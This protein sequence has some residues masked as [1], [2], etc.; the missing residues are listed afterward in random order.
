M[1]NLAS[2]DNPLLQIDF[3]PICFDFFECTSTPYDRASGNT[4]L[5]VYKS[6]S[7]TLE[8]VLTE[9]KNQIKN[10]SCHQKRCWIKQVAEGNE[11]VTVQTLNATGSVD[12]DEDTDTAG[13]VEVNVESSEVARPLRTPQR[14][15]ITRDITDFDGPWRLLRQCIGVKVEDVRQN[16]TRVQII[17]EIAKVASTPAEGDW[18]RA[19]LLQGWK[20]S[21]R[22]GDVVDCLDKQKV[23]REAVV[24]DVYEDGDLKVHFT[25]WGDEFDEIIGRWNIK[26]YIQPLFSKTVD[27][28]A[29]L[30]EDDSVDVMISELGEKRLWLSAVVM[31]KDVRQ[32]RVLV[33]YKKSAKLSVLAKEAANVSAQQISHAVP[34]PVVLDAVV[35][36]AAI[37][38]NDS[39]LASP[40]G[41]NNRCEDD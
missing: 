33:Q 25:G 2:N 13:S 1:I 17:F 28:R 10:Y 30:D 4:G 27:W 40:T 16:Q 19:E 39:L 34:P 15:L 3:Y 8:S 37:A 36:S 11:S 18:P 35:G 38:E 5:S 22:P 12:V 20:K 6:K 7:D 31:E 9:Y 41:N 32:K 29:R 24:T 21:L 14:R 26:D 23:F